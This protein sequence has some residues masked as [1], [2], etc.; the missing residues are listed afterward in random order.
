MDEINGCSRNNDGKLR[1]TPCHQNATFCTSQAHAHTEDR[2][3][4]LQLIRLKPKGVTKDFKARSL[5]A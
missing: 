1:S 2:G 3:Y 5:D 4:K